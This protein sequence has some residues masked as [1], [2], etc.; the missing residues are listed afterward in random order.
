MSELVP[1]LHDLFKLTRL[2]Q[3]VSQWNSQD[4]E[5]FKAHFPSSTRT[6]QGVLQHHDWFGAGYPSEPDTLYLHIADWLASAFSRPSEKEEGIA[7]FRLHKL[8]KPLKSGAQE[9]VRL[10]NDSEITALLNFCSIDP[11]WESFAKKYGFI[12]LNRAEDAAAGKNITSLYTHCKL[13]GQFYRILKSS[14]QFVVSPSELGGK[15]REQVRSLVKDKRSNKWQL[16]VAKSKFHFFQNPCRA[17][18]LNIFGALEDLIGEIHSLYPDN[19]LFKTSDEL[20]LVLTDGKQLSD[21]ATKAQQR[22][23]WTEIIK[24]RRF[25]NEVSPTPEFMKGTPNMKIYMVYRQRFLLP[26]VT[27]VRQPGR[28]GIGLRTMF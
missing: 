15:T 8:W 12:L 11:S 23:F 20:L 6:W 21:I 10:Q 19:V 22:G 13:T 26:S 16:V 1:E 7:N 27:S 4:F 9:D 18:D 14:S 3:D 28:Q 2:D 25:L 5:A 24:N 17:R